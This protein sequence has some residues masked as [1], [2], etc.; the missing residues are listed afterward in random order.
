MFGFGGGGGSGCE[1]YLV[2][3]PLPKSKR[4]KFDKGI[5]LFFVKICL[6]YSALSKMLKFW[7]RPLPKLE[8]FAATGGGE[9]FFFASDPKSP[10]G[11]FGYPR[12]SH[13]PPPLATPKLGVAKC[14]K[15]SAECSEC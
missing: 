11:T 9:H 5:L 14:M 13:P 6:F 10:L 15:G 12:I 8:G 2:C 1:P 3:H 4:Q 7:G